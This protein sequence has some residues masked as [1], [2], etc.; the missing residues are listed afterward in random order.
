MRPED[1]DEADIASKKWW[2][3]R[4]LGFTF[5]RFGVYS[6]DYNNH[7]TGEYYYKMNPY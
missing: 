4:L 1:F 3:I 7:L 5:V 2:A 6:N